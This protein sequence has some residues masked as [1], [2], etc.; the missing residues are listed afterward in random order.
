ML[1]RKIRI[2]NFISDKEKEEIYQY[3]RLL[4]IQKMNI[5]L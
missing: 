1:S 4:K 5:T 3:S 2:D